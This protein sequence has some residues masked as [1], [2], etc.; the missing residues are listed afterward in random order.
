MRPLLCLLICLIVV[1]PIFGCRYSE[2]RITVPHGYR[3][4]VLLSCQTESEINVSAAVDDLGNGSL[5]T[6]PT[7]RT[8]IY[9]IQD[10]RTTAV[11]D[12]Q[13]NKTGDGHLT[14]VRI[15]IR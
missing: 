13:W 14:G 7:K 8:H 11:D 5:A 1:A 9:V 10:G 3:G 4:T 6:C 12:A 2:V 15:A